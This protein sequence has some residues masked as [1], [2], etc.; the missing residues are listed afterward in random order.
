MKKNKAKYID[1]FVFVVP[2]K[3]LAAYRQMAKEASTIWMKCGALEYMECMGDDLAI[4]EMGG[5][6]GLSFLKLAQV[7]AN[8]T[9][10]FSYITY[11]SKAHRNQVNK[12]VNKEMEKISDKY[13]NMKMPF[14]MRKMAYGGFKVIVGV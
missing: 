2:K 7:K 8:E 1:G 12:K 9:V 10:W 13:K 4:T 5:M 6:K 14:D 3:N 11:K